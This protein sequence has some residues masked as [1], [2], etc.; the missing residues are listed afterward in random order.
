MVQTLG[1]SLPNLGALPA[2]VIGGLLG[3]I[4]HLA[5]PLPAM[6]DR[7]AMHTLHSYELAS[8]IL[9]FLTYQIN[10]LTVLIAQKP[11]LFLGLS[12][13]FCTIH[14]TFGNGNFLCLK[15]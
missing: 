2:P 4:A 6:P 12:L 14:E 10:T 8:T 9:V 7:R 15:I 11:L 1:L 5:K 13:N 3:L